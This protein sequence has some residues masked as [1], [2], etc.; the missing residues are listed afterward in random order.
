MIEK[1]LLN[2]IVLYIYTYKN[3]KYEKSTSD[4]FF[5][6]FM[7]E[8]RENVDIFLQKKELN[9]A[10]NYM[11]RRLIELQNNGYKIRKINQAYFAFY[12]N[13]GTSPSSIHTY[14]EDLLELIGNVVVNSSK[15][16]NFLT[17]KLLYTM[18]ENIITSNDSIT[19]DGSWGK[20]VGKGFK[21]NIEN[22][23]L[24]LGGRPKLS[25]NNNKGNIK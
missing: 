4:N 16:T 24:S 19:V 3:I 11:D 5:R 14:H 7:K 13:Y 20:L 9:K 8:T 2:F 12:G 15:G 1:I 22:S 23:M 6:T 10:D 18:K 17:N 25:L 21:Y